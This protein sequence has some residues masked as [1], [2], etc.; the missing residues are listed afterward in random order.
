MR[1]ISYNVNG[2]RAAMRKGLV[3]WLNEEKPDVLCVQETKAHPEQV[4]VKYF[5]HL[6]YKHYWTSAEK[7]GYSGVAIFSREAPDNIETGCGNP[8]YDSEGRII[9]ADFGELSIVNTY[10]PSGSSGDI[11]QDFKMEFLDCYLGFIKKLKKE[12]PK[13]IVA[14]DYNICHKPIDIHDPVSNK[15]SSGFLPEE[16]E[17]MDQYFESGMIDTFRKF[18]SSPDNY[19]WWSYRARARERN[20]GWRIDYIATTEN[21]EN[22]LE[23]AGIMQEA[24][25]SDH[26][27]VYIDLKL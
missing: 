17:W 14:G 4:D 13:L 12:R 10:F 20:K 25:H 19:S 23:D 22:N 2:I 21:L 16:R 9:R 11:R 5:E 8:K 15:D 24:M 6:G 18:D 7:K 3:E 1:I 27:P 26:C